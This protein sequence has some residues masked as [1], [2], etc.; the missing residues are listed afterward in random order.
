MTIIVNVVFL[1]GCSL[2][3]KEK[4]IDSVTVDN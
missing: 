1:G 2:A 4:K 3:Y